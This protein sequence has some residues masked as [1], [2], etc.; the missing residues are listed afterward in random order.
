MVSVV[1]DGFLSVADV[2][3]CASDLHAAI[4]SL[5]HWA[6]RHVTL[7][8]LRAAQVVA[9]DALERVSQ[10][11]LDPVYADIQAKRVAFV[12]SSP[13]FGRQMS[14]IAAIRDHLRAFNDRDAAIAWLLADHDRLRT[15]SHPTTASG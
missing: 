11:F 15:T 9:A 5:G 8:D 2:D 13:L 6:G 7:Y 12:T 4:R 14:R 3:R 10:Y 1:C